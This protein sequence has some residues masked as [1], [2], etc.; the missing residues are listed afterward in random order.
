MEHSFTRP[1]LSGFFTD[2]RVE[3]R[4]L[5]QMNNLE[6]MT[7]Y[8]RGKFE[9]EQSTNKSLVEELAEEKEKNRLLTSELEGHQSINIRLNRLYIEVQKTK[10]SLFD[11]LAEEKEKNQLLTNEL[12]EGQSSNKSLDDE[13]AEE[14]S[15]LRYMADELEKE[16]ANL[17]KI[18]YDLS[19]EK[20]VSHRLRL[21]R[22]V[23]MMCFSVGAISI[24]IYDWCSKLN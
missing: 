13:L 23:Y 22:M 1:S 11:K 12:A 21:E 20:S 17:K 4:F 18:A 24:L 8:W 10:M 16:K 6:A 7:Q 19:K 5:I 9:E 14:Q 15:A 2:S 3:S